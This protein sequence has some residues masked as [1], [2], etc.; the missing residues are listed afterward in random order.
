M[1]FIAGTTYY[2]L[3]DPEA[4]GA[5]SVS[6]N[7][8][9]P[10]TTIPAVPT[11]SAL[12]NTFCIPN[13]AQLT[14]SGMAPG[15]RVINFTSATET[16]SVMYSGVANTFTM[17]LW[18]N[19]TSQIEVLSETNLSGIYFG[20]NGNQRY[21]V[22][23]VHGGATNAGAGI[24]VGTNGV[25]VFEHGDAYIPSI[26]FWQGSI[27]GW[28]HIAVVYNAKTP[29]LYVNGQLVRTGLTST[30]ANVY[31]SAG[32]GTG[33][34]GKYQGAIDNYRIWN[35]A[36]TQAQ[37]Q[38]NMHYRTPASVVGLL[39]HYTF[40]NNNTNATV[41]TNL[42]NSGGTFS[43]A[44][45]YTYTWSGGP[46]LPAPSL[47]EQQSTGNITSA[48]SYNYY[49]TATAGACPGTLAGPLA[50]NVVQPS[51]SGMSTGDY[52]WGGTQPFYTS[53]AEWFVYNG[54]G[55]SVAS[56][57]PTA[58]DNVFI[59]PIGVCATIHPH[60]WSSDI[61]AKDLTIRPGASLE[62]GPGPG[63]SL[64]MYGSFYNNSGNAANIINSGTPTVVFHPGPSPTRQIGGNTPSTFVALSNNIGGGYLD[65]N[66]PITVINTLNMNSSFWLN[67]RLILGVSPSITGTLNHSFPAGGWMAG[68]GYFRRY[69]AASTN[70]AAAGN[71]PLGALPSVYW[72]QAIIQFTTAP[73][74]GGW[75]EGRFVETPLTY[76]NGL[77]IMND[78]GVD[79]QN[80][81]NEGYW[82]LN[83]GG[84]LAGG[85]YTLT[86]QRDGIGTVTDPSLLRIL[87]SPDPHI[88]WVVDGAHGV[89]TGG[90]TAGTISRTGM[91]GF[92]YFVISSDNTN[93]LPVQLLTFNA[94]CKDGSVHLNW[95]TATEVNN[96]YFVVEKSNNGNTWTEVEVQPGGGNSNVIRYYESIDSKPFSGLSYYRLRQVDY[97][98]DQ[99]TFGPLSVTC[100]N[101]NNTDYAL[102]YP[103]PTN[104]EFT[105]ELNAGNAYGNGVI[106]IMDMLGR[107][108][109]VREIN[110]QE[111]SNIITF[112]DEQLRAGTYHISIQMNGV[113]LPVQK[114]VI[115]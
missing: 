17:E 71:F 23:P 19:P 78:A 98:G 73:S 115:K 39:G 77:P 27:T 85:L 70:T 101:I 47:N 50:I 35:S 31:P 13:Y 11:L 45:Y 4:T 34:Y 93:P 79:I 21:A 102:I 92:S 80:Y 111:G 69:F 81:M 60:L 75:I 63:G 22:Y 76:Y 6:F 114:L 103:N 61:Y 91:S 10:C 52:V 55:F 16:N 43:N 104:G 44:N 62:L 72:R 14:A 53:A 8:V 83:P 66:Q 90:L 57:A 26:L 51:A 29:S 105:V 112:M 108:V 87:K 96:D 88:S 84:G 95:A 64:N 54:T 2:I 3:L 67:N 68:P 32:V 65:I 89:V 46:A 28:T 58:N 25:A 113:S 48:G 24:S 15:G 5:Y 41:G 106:E 49:V 33:G 40:D 9:C 37:I 110:I 109:V 1:N 56:N 82:E 12:S 74:S 18:V 100:I 30:R 94:Q 7:L 97:N 59:D 107:K 38:A 86:L 36:R 20:T 42:T 99:E